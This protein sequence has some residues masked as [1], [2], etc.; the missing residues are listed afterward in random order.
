MTINVSN[1]EVNMNLCLSGN[2]TQ[3]NKNMDRKK[4]GFFFSDS[5]LIMCSAWFCK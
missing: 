5:V 3:T 2:E 4:K 1:I